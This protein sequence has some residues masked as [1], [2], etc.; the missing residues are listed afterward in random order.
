MYESFFFNS[1]YTSE[2]AEKYI[3]IFVKKVKKVINL[4]NFYEI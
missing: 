3:I 2:K 1:Q 4:R